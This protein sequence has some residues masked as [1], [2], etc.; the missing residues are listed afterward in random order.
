MPKIKT[1]KG[2]AKRFVITKNG[3]IKHRKAFGAHILEK[4]G[5]SRK[6]TYAGVVDTAKGDSKTVRKLLGKIK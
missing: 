1:H 6:R 3:K 2:T 5:E 4:K